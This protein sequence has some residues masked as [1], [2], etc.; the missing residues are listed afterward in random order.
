MKN[1]NKTN[2]IAVFVYLGFWITTLLIFWLSEED[3]M[4]YSLLFQTGLLCG[5]LP[6]SL[7]L[8]YVVRKGFDK[9]IIFLPITCGLGIV[10]HY[11]FTFSLKNMIAFSKINLISFECFL[12]PLIP[13]LLG[14]GIGYIILKLRKK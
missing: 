6:F 14:I 13:S 8:F 1:S 2:L 12:W 5:V 10:L 7:S 9:E 3:A 11:Y 4:G